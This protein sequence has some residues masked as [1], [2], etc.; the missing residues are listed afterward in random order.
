MQGVHQLT[1]NSNGGEWETVF[2]MIAE[3]VQGKGGTLELI[4]SPFRIR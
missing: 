2:R 4:A 1:R 3:D